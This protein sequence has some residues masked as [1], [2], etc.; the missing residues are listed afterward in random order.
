MMRSF[1]KIFSWVLCGMALVF[2][3]QAASMS[4]PV[5][6][7]SITGYARSPQIAAHMN[8][9]YV[10][11]AEGTAVDQYDIYVVRSANY[12]ESWQ[13]PVRIAT[14]VATA[15][16]SPQVAGGKNGI[17]VFWTDNFTRNS[18]GSGIRFARSTDGGA[19]FS[20][21]VLAIAKANGGYT[22]PSS[23]IVDASGVNDR[24]FFS[25]YDSRYANGEEI[26]QAMLIVSCDAGASF[27]AVQQVSE[28]DRAN[29][30]ESPRLALSSDGS[31]LFMLYRS[32]LDGTPQEGWPPF[33]QRLIRSSNI[34]CAASPPVTWLNPSQTVSSALP[35]DIGNTY[36]GLL[37]A[38]ANGRFHLGYW[39]ESNGN[40]L[41]YRTGDPFATGWGDP[42]D[43]TSPVA[44]Y[45]PNHLEFDGGAAEYGFFGVG[46]DPSANL[47]VA[48]FQ[49][50]ATT[51]D[52]FK[53][54]KIF[55]RK[56]TYSAGS[57]GFGEVSTIV[58]SDLAFDP[59]AIVVG[60]RLATVWADFRDHN[61]G[62]GGSEIYYRHV[63]TQSLAGRQISVGATALEFGPQLITST[64]AP[65]TVSI[66]MAGDQ[67][68]TVSGVTATGPFAA[69]TDCSTQAA[70]SSC[71]VMVTFSPIVVGAAAG[72]LT[73]N[74]NAVNAPHT[75]SLSGTG[76]SS[77]IDHYYYSIL[78]RAPEPSGK[79]FWE[80]EVTRL[81]GLGVD[82]KEVYIV[83]AN[84]FFAGGEYLAK[85]SSDTTF[86]GNLYR[87]FFAR[88]P[89][90]S[91]IGYW[92]G[93]LQQAMPRD[94][95]MF[96]F[97][98][99]SEFNTFS[100][101]FF[102]AAPSRA[103]VLAVVDYYRGIL[104]RLPDSDGLAFWVSRF[105]AAQCSG[106]SAVYQQADTISRD[107]FSS[108]EYLARNRSNSQYVSDLYNAFLRRGGDLAGFDFWV[109]ALGNAT[110]TREDLRQAF[111]T[112]PEFAA[113]VNA[114]VVVGCL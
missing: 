76:G 108:G 14:G 5:R 82:P 113:R 1:G 105:R 107:F 95:V 18:G 70:G 42:V 6:L 58:A 33:S 23:V 4:A 49:G 45:G 47:H 101:S 52:G 71:S 111:L 87:T 83:M 92:Q 48:M 2:D 19:S 78:D 109:S 110:R 37:V 20:S 88:N 100:S 62:A 44:G 68:V 39:S 34:D 54:G 56:G 114:I 66:S 59:R 38:G 112:A 15:S 35:E 53:V 26:G 63:F 80:N 17:Y 11:W 27:S 55:Y 69:T 86:L 41:I 25:W 94:I 93:Q 21:P 104:G 51:I 99:S 91:G 3:V 8:N 106:A 97:L 30:A 85:N 79:S 13:P 28:N 77:L 64:G 74:S 98:F 12:G 90:A 36:G 40:N 67:A 22:R 9:L 46:E 89:D 43:L 73:I 32:S 65:R 103:E 7:S 102:G 50:S 84:Y 24:I 72:T 16:P 57:Y 10:V 29:D 96:N 60:D 31:T 61:N 75:V 81:A